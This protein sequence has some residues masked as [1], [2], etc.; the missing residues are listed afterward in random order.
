[1]TVCVDNILCLHKH[2]LVILDLP[3]EVKTERSF[4]NTIGTMRK[5]KLCWEIM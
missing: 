3:G 2:K 5:I 4:F 1:M